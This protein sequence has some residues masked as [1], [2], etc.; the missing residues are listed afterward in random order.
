M[1]Q[2]FNRRMNFLNLKLNKNIIKI[3]VL[4]ESIILKT[5]FYILTESLKK[6]IITRNNIKV[7]SVG[8][9]FYNERC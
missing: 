3:K 9:E 5:A 6:Q 1:Y 8:R 7:I 2:N 4:I